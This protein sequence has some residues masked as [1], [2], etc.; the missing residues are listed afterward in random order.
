MPVPIW[1][2]YIYWQENDRDFI[3]ALVF[4]VTGIATLTIPCAFTPI[5]VWYLLYAT[6]LMIEVLGQR[7]QSLGNIKRIEKSFSSVF[8]LQITSS[9]ICL[10]SIAYLMAATSENFNDTAMYLSLGGI[11]TL[12]IFVLIY[13]AN[14][15]SLK[16]DRLSGCIYESNW[17][18]M[19]LMF[20]KFIV[21]IGEKWKKPK[22]LVENALGITVVPQ[23]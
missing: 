9:A 15:I 1:L 14:E 20:R 11:Y 3:I 18:C 22:Q 13:F 21:I 19:P 10:C 8:F 7:L 6:S 12:D 4:S 2:P 17:T 23:P 16:S 5:I